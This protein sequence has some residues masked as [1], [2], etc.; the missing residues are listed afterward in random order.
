MNDRSR[1]YKK[2]EEISKKENGSD[3]HFRLVHRSCGPI[4]H[5]SFLAFCFLYPFL[6]Y[7]FVLTAYI[8]I[9]ILTFPKKSKIYIFIYI[10]SILIT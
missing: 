8:Y 9:H 7:Y 2:K 4:K 6:F 5:G 1:R 3:H 10:V